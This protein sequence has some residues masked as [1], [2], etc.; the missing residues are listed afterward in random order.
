M[1]NEELK[2]WLRDN[3]SGI[4]R[5]AAEAADRIGELEKE[6]E[7]ERQIKSRIYKAGMVYFR[8]WMAIEKKH[9]RDA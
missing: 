8:K 2:K 9:S 5:P 4:Y 1:T 7:Q 6:L 3:C